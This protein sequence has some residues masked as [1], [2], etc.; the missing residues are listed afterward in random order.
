MALSAV[1]LAG[2]D[3]HSQGKLTKF[4]YKKATNV[5]HLKV[6]AKSGVLKFKVTANTDCG[7]HQGDTGNK[8]PC[9]TLGKP[10]YDNKVVRVT[11]TLSSSG[12]RKASLVAV[13]M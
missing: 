9:K 11:W 13:D 12:A 2:T 10:K 6:T 1:A 4:T 3:H 7:V 5:G 8:I